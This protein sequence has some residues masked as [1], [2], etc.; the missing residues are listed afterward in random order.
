MR[1][2]AV[3]IVLC[4]AVVLNACSQGGPET[5]GEAAS[6][7]QPGPAGP[8]GPEGDPGLVG[9]RGPPGP[10]GPPGPAGAGSMRVVR[11]DCSGASCAASCDQSEVLVTAYCGAT[12][13]PAVFPSERSASCRARTRANSPVVAL[14]A[15]EQPEDTTGAH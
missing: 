5:K 11:S 4:A 15:K 1:I 10:P 3:M 2:P 13:N 6:T 12:H 9:E 8:P 7:G 14:C